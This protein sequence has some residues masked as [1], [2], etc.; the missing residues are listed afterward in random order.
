MKT[1]KLNE[2]L[3]GLP[4]NVRLFAKYAYQGMEY[5]TRK[6]G[7][8]YHGINLIIKNILFR[9]NK[10]KERKEP[11]YLDDI[12]KTEFTDL[13]VNGLIILEQKR[14]IELDEERGKYR[15]F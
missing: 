4:N 12:C 11:P 15:I 14:L 9:F 8:C 13:L 7:T 1:E 6:Y 2:I 5:Q 10:R 3:D